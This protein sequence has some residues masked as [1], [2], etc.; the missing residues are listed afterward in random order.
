MSAFMLQLDQYRRDID[1][2]SAWKRAIA[3]FISDMTTSSYQEAYA[4]LEREM[5]PGGR[6]QFT[7]PDILYLEKKT[8]GNR[9]KYQSTFLEYLQYTQENNHIMAPTFTTYVQ[10]HQKKSIIAEY[11]QGNKKLRAVYKKKQLAAEIEEI[12]E[13]VSFN[14]G[15]Q[16]SI[17]A[18]NNSVSGAHSSP[19]N[20]LYLRSGHSTLTSGCRSATSYSN[21]NNEKLLAGN[22][23]YWSPN[24]VIADLI[25]HGL[26]SN[27]DD[28][29]AVLQRYNLHV[30]T[31]EDVMACI[32]YNTY[33][34]YWR[35]EVSMQA[36]R[37]YVSTMTPAARASFLYNGDMYHLAKHNDTVVRQFLSEVSQIDT[38]TQ[39]DAH[40]VAKIIDSDILAMG[41]LICSEFIAGRL[42]KDVIA[43]TPSDY[44]VLMATC[45]RIKTV[46]DN[47]ADFVAV[48][49]RPNVMTPS[50][51]YVPNMIR[52]AVVTSDTDSTIFTTQY[53]SEWF[54]GREQLFSKQ[55]Y[56]IA[57]GMTY[58]VS[59]TVKHI[60]AQLSVN[61]GVTNDRIG[62]LSMK[63]EFFMD[64]Y[65]LTTNAK[66]YFNYTSACEGN[67]YRS[68]KLDVKGVGLRSSN[69]PP[70]VTTDC[71][72]Y[73]KYIMDKI[74][75]EG[76]LMHSELCN[77]VSCIEES[78]LNSI[79]AGGFEY[80]RTQQI[81]QAE[82][83]V[84][85]EEAAGYQYYAMWLE[86]F[87]PKYGFPDAP[88]FRAV[89]VSLDLPNKTKLHKWLDS[90]EDAG[91]KTR[92]KDWVQ[93]TGKQNL[94]TM[95]LPEAALAQHGIPKELIPVVESRRLL[96]GVMRPFYLTIESCGISMLNDNITRLCME[97]F[98]ARPSQLIDF[99]PETVKQ[100]Q[101]YTAA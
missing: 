85:G 67:V 30:P 72:D 58:I 5:V 75:Y 9:K 73:M 32:H 90:I 6:L 4:Y 100:S 88:P 46:F 2:L 68:R 53:W 35:S 23:H 96:N 82:S 89:K 13:L 66:H 27:A 86:V 44:N 10:P 15:L 17:K 38:V 36:V 45:L 12:H 59:Q 22:R 81:K 1:I 24:V 42:L 41:S 95:M 80:M 92:L 18:K 63:N 55:G 93:R 101:W 39:V 79:H 25:N 31:V 97:E 91:I 74:I 77:P 48:L 56:N 83:Y 34:N 49:I 87:S 16:T 94:T 43:N 98:K 7:D 8:R 70:R 21:A 11:I 20:A 71:H 62:M 64:I 84:N 50:I 61:F 69:A 54:C 33:E 76:G 19:Y 14:G 26:Y 99:I 40:A 52:K 60:L 28:M 78:V 37:T 51:A 47:Y 29:M 57:Y 3:K 65:A